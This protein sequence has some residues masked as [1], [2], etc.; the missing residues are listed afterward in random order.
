MA[1]L[2][3]FFQILTILIV[4][5]GLILAFPSTQ[6]VIASQPAHNPAA[7]DPASALSPRVAGDELWSSLFELGANAAIYAIAAAPNG[8]IYAA[9][10]FT[11]IAGIN[12]NHVARW[13]AAN[14]QWSALGAG[15]NN[16][17]YT[18]AVSGDYLYAAGYFNAA[19]R[20]HWNK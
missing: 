12:A 7:P 4:L 14:G 2:R 16:H 13:S 3:Q 10:D 20:P 15:I 1:K 9:G 19:D 6:N 18:L 5:P 8:D 11:R 17:G